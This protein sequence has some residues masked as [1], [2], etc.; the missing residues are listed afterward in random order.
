LSTAAFDARLQCRRSAEWF[1][2]RRLL[3]LRM[4]EPPT[5]HTPPRET[6]PGDDSSAGIT[7]I[8]NQAQGGD[9]V[10]RERVYALLYAELLRLARS[11]L[12]GSQPVSLNPSALV[13]EAYLR[14]LGRDTMPI[15]DR[16]AFFAYASTVM[17][18]VLIDHARMRAA[19]KRGGHYTPV[20]LTTGLLNN[21]AAEADLSRL[22]DALEALRGVDERCFRVVE[23]RY[24]AGM[25]EQDIADELA[26]SVPTIKRAWRKARAFLYEQMD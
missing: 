5:R 6:A 22:N 1:A 8:L 3:Q 10:A 20:T 2:D 13:H 4:S 26:V 23:M 12:S 14:M 11:H 7:L 24:F 15:R 16:R 19:D 18:S 9:S 21:V 25:T 17:R